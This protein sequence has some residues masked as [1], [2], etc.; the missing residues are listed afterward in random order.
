M[1]SCFRWS[2]IYELDWYGACV[3]PGVVNS[4]KSDICEPLNDF[5]FERM[6]VK[7]LV[8]SKRCEMAELE[9]LLGMGDL[10]RSVSDLIHAVQR[11]RGASNLHLGSGG[12]AFGDEMSKMVLETDQSL[13]AL[14]A[15]WTRMGER[16]TTG[17]DR[18]RLLNR[19][20]HAAHEL[21]GLVGLRSKVRDL[22]VTPRKG[23]EAYSELVRYL[24]AIVFEAADAALDPLISRILVA[25]FHFMEGKEFAGQER[26][27]GAGAIA[28]GSV[29]EVTRNRI[30]RMID[31]QERCFE[32]FEEFADEQSV[33]QWRTGLSVDN[34]VQLEKLRRIVCTDGDSSKM[35]SDFG[36]TWFECAT[37]RI[38]GMKLI[39]NRVV[40]KLQDLCEEKLAEARASQCSEGQGL[41][42][43]L[44][45]E[46]V[47]DG[48]FVLYFAGVAL[49]EGAVL[50]PEI[51]GSRLGRSLLELLQ[52]QAQR[53][54]K[55]NEELREVKEALEDRKLIEKAKGLLMKHRKLSEQEAHKMLRDL[56]MKQS[57]RM[58]EVAGRLVSMEGV[59][60]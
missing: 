16:D 24:L 28:T 26:A 34:Q 17:I 55:L 18:T 32:V 40:E 15:A 45:K 21:A 8:A 27:M 52:G 42:G 19:M 14:V 33:V 47:A 12:E 58:A 46:A 51:G 36:R 29:D 57:C 37:R 30:L 2:A 13:G 48:G 4:S 25:L 10:V 7:F 43:S 3:L 38:D 56:A 6:A 23:M 22:K 11:E 49:N 9:T 39:E 60:D 35:G 44:T 53:L 59:W 5:A 31:E 20:A 50:T 1:P 41:E 54:H